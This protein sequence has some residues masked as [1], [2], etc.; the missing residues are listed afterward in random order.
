MADVMELDET[1]WSDMNLVGEKRVSVYSQ[2]K[3]LAERAAWDFL[4]EVPEGEKKPE[5]V[6][7][8]PG[9]VLGDYICGGVSSSPALIKSL[10]MNTM[11]GIP[12]LGFSAVDMSDVI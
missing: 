6:T 5:L 2:S 3:T 11:P 7:I 1:H 4:K 12:R 8:L 10:L 9:L